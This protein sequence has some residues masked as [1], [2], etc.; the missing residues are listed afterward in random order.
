[1]VQDNYVIFYFLYFSSLELF[2]I[3]GC[4][5]NWLKKVYYA[6]AKV[7]QVILSENETLWTMEIM[8]KLTYRM[9]MSSKKIN[10]L[11]ISFFIIFFFFI[12]IKISAKYQDKEGLQKKLAKDIKTF[13]KKKKKM[14]RNDILNDTK[15]YQK[16][17]NESW[18]SRK[19]II[20]WEKMS[21]CNYKK[22]I[23]VWKI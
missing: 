21:Y 22:T 20:K 17:K 9:F 18:L 2:I 12:Y 11:L 14:T 4:E 3:V 8:I 10:F 23:F 16:I 1:M 19:N 6:I 15:N 7:I 5:K 13:L